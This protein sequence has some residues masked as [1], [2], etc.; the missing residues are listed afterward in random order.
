MILNNKR[1]SELQ[2][3]VEMLKNAYDLIDDALTAEQDCFDNI[4]ENLQGSDMGT[5]MEN[6]IDVMEGVLSDID[7]I[8]DNIEGII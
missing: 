2:T 1:R 6:N 3:S 8:I 7:D 4:P 5:T